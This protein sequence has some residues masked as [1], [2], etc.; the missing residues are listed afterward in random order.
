MKIVLL[1]NIGIRNLRYKDKLYTDLEE[2]TKSFRQWSKELLENYEEFKDDLQVNILDILLED[3]KDEIEEIFLFTSNQGGDIR[4]DQ[5]TVNEGRII[6]KLIEKMYKGTRVYLKEIA[7]PVTDINFLLK[8]YR[9]K[10]KEIFKSHAPK[11]HYIVNDAGG[12][13][14]QKMALKILCEYLLEEDQYNVFYVALEEHG[15][16]LREAEPVEYRRIIDSEQAITLSR[17][18]QYK[19]AIRLIGNTNEMAKK[20]LLIAELLKEGLFNDL[21]KFIKDECLKKEYLSIPIISRLFSKKAVGKNEVL[22]ELLKPVHFFRLGE[23]LSLLQKYIELKFF[24]EAILTAYRFQELYL[25]SIIENMKGIPLISDFSQAK[26]LLKDKKI[27][28]R[29]IPAYVELTSDINDDVHRGILETIR[30]SI[31]FT[32]DKNFFVGDNA[33]NKLRHEYTHRGRGVSEVIFNSLQY[34][35]IFKKWF[36]WYGLP[37]INEYDELND[38]IEKSLQ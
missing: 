16:V 35:D 26:K 30:R 34:K 12:T 4:N 6:G 7:G 5:D 3:H 15:P 9:G 37:E 32:E 33:I 2:N 11:Q 19:A 22:A 25:M 28:H 17:N 29:G 14:Q 38:Q 13:P 18:L 27:Y 31:E 36:D 23:T 24:S 1:S 20:L 8:E 21:E 10:L